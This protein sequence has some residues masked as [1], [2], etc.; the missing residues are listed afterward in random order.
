MKIELKL[1]DVETLLYT[2]D[3]AIFYQ[4]ARCHDVSHLEHI[5]KIMEIQVKAYKE[6]VIAELKKKISRRESTV[7]NFVAKARG[8]RV[9]ARCT[10][11]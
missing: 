3:K 2:L 6:A 8:L 10:V 1:Y 9:F 4:K 7:S 11:L 5:K